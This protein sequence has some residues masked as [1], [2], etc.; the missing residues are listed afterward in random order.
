MMKTKTRIEETKQNKAKIAFLFSSR[1]IYLLAFDFLEYT[2][3]LKQ[4][5]GLNPLNMS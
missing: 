3:E 1:V 5:S 4:L 2:G